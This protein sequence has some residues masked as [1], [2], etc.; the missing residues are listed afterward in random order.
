[1]LGR[2]FTKFASHVMK[3]KIERDR[4]VVNYDNNE[5]DTFDENGVKRRIN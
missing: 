4:R 5:K 3:S 2:L 1:M